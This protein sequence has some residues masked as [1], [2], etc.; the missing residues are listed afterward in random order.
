MGFPAMLPRFLAYYSSRMR[1]NEE[2][3][4]LYAILATQWVVE[5]ASVWVASLKSKGYLWHLSNAL[6]EGMCTLTPA[7]LG[8]GRDGSM[9]TSSRR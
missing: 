7:R 8:D 5:V 3:H 2:G 6:V 4:R 9:P 1:Q